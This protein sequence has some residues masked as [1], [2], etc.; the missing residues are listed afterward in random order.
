MRLPLLLLIAF[1][2][3][4]V[5]SAQLT[6]VSPLQQTLVLDS[7]VLDLGVI[8]P[9]QTLELI[10]ERGSGEISSQSQTKG[11]SLWDQLFVERNSLPSSWKAE[12]SKLFE[13][14]FRA[15]VTV[16]PD[17]ADGEYE[18]RIKAVDLYEG[19]QEKFYTA[20]VRVS[21]DLLEF[22]V[23]PTVL[24]AGAG[25]PAVLQL[26]LR[27]KSSASDVFQINA[28][29][30]PSQWKETR[31]IFVPF[32]SETMVSYEILAGEQGEFNVL[33]TANSL[34]SNLI[35]AGENVRLTSVSSLEEDLR[36]MQRGMLLFPTAEQVV[37][38]LLGLVSQL[39]YR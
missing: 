30:I 4:L 21:K 6:V 3:P 35:S 20:K 39:I 2:S 15:F 34:S 7:D 26:R 12:D 28:T 5:F 13:S 27:N 8:G 25:L 9:G 33:I 18:F 17:A 38:S 37:Y 23:S 1:L 24:R 31:E 10:A 11:E 22:D 19:A 16:A 32:N 14:P 36:S 29:G